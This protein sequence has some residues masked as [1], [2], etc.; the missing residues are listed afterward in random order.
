MEQPVPVLPVLPARML[1]ELRGLPVLDGAACHGQG[2]KWDDRLPD[3]DDDDRTE[4]HRLAVQVCKRC[5]A[6]WACAAVAASYR[7]GQ[8]DG[9]WA[10]QLRNTPRTRGPRG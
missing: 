5:P 4:R 6:R 3:E 9:V 1:S 7:P 2:G 10:G 8:L